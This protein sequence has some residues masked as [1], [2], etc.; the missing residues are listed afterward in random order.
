MLM[1]SRLRFSLAFLAGLALG[2]IAGSI[3]RALGGL[4]LNGL[5]D[6]D[7][8]I[9]ILTKSGVLLH[10]LLWTGGLYAIVG[11]PLLL[12]E[13]RR[14]RFSFLTRAVVGLLV[15]Y[16]ASYP[17]LLIPSWAALHALSGLIAAVVGYWAT[18]GLLKSI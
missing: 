13:V 9:Y 5:L 14:R 3:F 11:L 8:L 16:A 7:H 4:A 1:K 10:F 2:S 17:S 18:R 6:L 12:W 15:G